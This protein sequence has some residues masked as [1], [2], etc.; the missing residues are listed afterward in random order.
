MK[1]GLKP[2]Q[3]CNMLKR[4]DKTVEKY[5]LRWKGLDLL[6]H[7]PKTTQQWLETKI[8]GFIAVDDWSSG[9]P[10]FNPLC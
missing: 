8:T 6:V 5:S 2:G 7:K 4:R 10:D 1:K 9:N 3:K